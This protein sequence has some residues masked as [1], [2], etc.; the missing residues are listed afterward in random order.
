MNM[1]SALISLFVW[2]F[3]FVSGPIQHN[4][5]PESFVA[6]NN[7]YPIRVEGLSL[8]WALVLLL[9]SL[10]P[11]CEVWSSLAHELGHRVTSS[12]LVANERARLWRLKD[13]ALQVRA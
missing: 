9:Q 11:S 13:V 2:C 10:P 1:N 8:L 3:W 12:S 5:V 6:F 7:S 4:L